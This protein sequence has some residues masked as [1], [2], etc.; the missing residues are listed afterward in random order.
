ML[1]GL[2][3]AING[4]IDVGYRAA[5]PDLRLLTGKLVK[6]RGTDIIQGRMSM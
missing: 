5:L 3:P 4:I 2:K 1:G 6:H